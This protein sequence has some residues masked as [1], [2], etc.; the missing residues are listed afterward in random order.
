[1]DIE[2]IINEIDALDIEILYKLKERKEFNT[3]TNLYKFV[4]EDA[5]GITPQSILSE[6]EKNLYDFEKQNKY[7]YRDNIVKPYFREFK[8]TANKETLSALNSSLNDINFNQHIKMNYINFL[9]DLCEYGINEDNN[10]KI[11]NID[12]D[13]LLLLSKRVHIGITLLKAKFLQNPDLYT[14]LTRETRDIYINY[15]LRDY[16]YESN[17]ICKLLE[18]AKE[19]TLDETLI[20]QYYKMFIIP[21]F[22]EVQ[23]NYLTK[24]NL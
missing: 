6:L 24:L 14:K 11:V 23:Y 8:D 16:S 13:I 18:K 15:F 21:M 3:N 5:T 2:K 20:Y 1:M 9:Y 17:Y 22:I 7:L 4:Y 12:I 10:T 19:I